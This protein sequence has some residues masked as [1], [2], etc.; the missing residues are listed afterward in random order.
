MYHPR[1]RQRLA[2]LLLLVLP[3]ALVIS[4][5][6]DARMGKDDKAASDSSAIDSAL[7]KKV[8][9]EVATVERG[10][11]SDYIRLDGTLTTEASVE[12]FALVSGHV[13]S[14]RAEAGDRVRAGDT[15]L[16]LEDE[17]I[18]LAE[19]RT[20]NELAKAEQDL[21]R[22]ESLAER[23][24]VSSQELEE[25]RYLREAARL[26]WE[27]ARLARTRTRVT[28]PISGV[29][30]E[31]RVGKGAYIQP[32]TGLFRLVDDRELISVLDL[33]EREVARIAV[34][35]A[36]QVTLQGQERPLAGWI[37]RISPVVDPASGTVQVTVAVPG[38]GKALRSG[39][40][41]GFS[42]VTGT[43]EQAVLVP[44]RSLVY[45]RNRLIAFTVKDGKAQRKLL[46]KGYEDEDRIEVLAG[47]QP[48]DSL[49][50]VGQSSLKD[51]TEVRV[52]AGES[53]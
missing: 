11:I 47:I 36:V 42:I 21:I 7:A 24:L 34:R 35:Q 49:V 22:L 31:R 39:M 2:A 52:I 23:N 13:A 46:E 20:R 30:A 45:D 16:V 28:A 50:V 6:V 8:P 33:P 4:C 26:N 38:E 25:A 40:F 12:V 1:V 10:T 17:E 14:L 19:Q 5:S 15:L 53:R 27:S 37:K 44:K 51:R 29:V 41:A 32:S 48:G 9:V 18:L 43:R 3:S